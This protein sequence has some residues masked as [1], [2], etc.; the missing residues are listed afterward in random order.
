M[1]AHQRARVHKTYKNEV[2]SFELNL[3]NN[4]ATITKINDFNQINNT[5]FTKVKEKL[6]KLKKDSISYLEE[7]L[8]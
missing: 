6:E 4:I 3:E 5:D 7:S 1:K 2:I 8:K